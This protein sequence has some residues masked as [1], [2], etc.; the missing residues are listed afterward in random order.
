M[1]GSGERQPPKNLKVHLNA[2][3]VGGGGGSGGMIFG[4]NEYKI[5]HE[6]FV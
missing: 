5:E 4:R 1:G 6:G 3:G 2:H